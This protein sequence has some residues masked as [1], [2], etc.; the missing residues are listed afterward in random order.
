VQQIAA[1]IA[2]TIAVP[3]PESA[4]ERRHVTVMFCDLVDSTGIAAKLDAEEW[5]D[6][7][8]AYLD[9][10]SSSVT[11]MS[12]KVA[13]KLGDG[14]MALFG[15]PVA[16]ENDAERAVRAALSI[17]RALAELNRKNEGTGK[18]AL[19]ARK[20]T[21]VFSAPRSAMPRSSSSVLESSLAQVN[22]DPTDN[23]SLLAPL[24]APISPPAERALVWTAG[25][26]N[27]GRLD[28]GE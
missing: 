26:E 10:A 14:L 1:T 19:A 5:R 4:G 23:V 18:P 21:T 25:V 2:A 6:L 20:H 24:L 7:V 15:Y 9:A 28:R 16:Q 13:K 27:R 8:G 17:Q 12:G 3:A 22:L 11:E